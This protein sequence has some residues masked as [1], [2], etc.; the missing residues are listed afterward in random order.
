MGNA[1]LHF[2]DDEEE[3]TQAPQKPKGRGDDE[4]RQDVLFVFF[5]CFYEPK[6]IER[7]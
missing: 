2:D 6:V 5:A 7:K 1:C 3:V 4:T